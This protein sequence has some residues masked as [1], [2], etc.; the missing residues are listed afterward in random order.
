M[1][2]NQSQPSF[3]DERGGLKGLAGGLARHLLR[4]EPAQFL[5][6]QWQ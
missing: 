1:R 3:V 5:I 4:G 2:A 6:D